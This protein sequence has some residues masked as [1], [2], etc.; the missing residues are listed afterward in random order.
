MIRAN[1]GNA[2][3]AVTWVEAKHS[4]CR[5]K[6]LPLE[7]QKVI[8]HR[9]IVIF[10]KGIVEAPAPAYL[11]RARHRLLHVAGADHV[12]NR[13]RVK[14]QPAPRPAFLAS[15]EGA[16]TGLVHGHRGTAGPTTTPAVVLGC[17]RACAGGFGVMS[18]A[19]ARVSQAADETTVTARLGERHKADGKADDRTHRLAFCRCV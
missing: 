18:G 6:V 19:Y 11:M 4:R 3:Q 13:R 5:G 9:P 12:S 2:K 10:Y 8:F 14:V 1:G 16:G 15:G 7:W 17:V